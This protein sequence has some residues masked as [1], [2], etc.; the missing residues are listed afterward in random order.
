VANLGLS[1]LAC[2]PPTLSIRPFFSLFSAHTLSPLLAPIQGAS[3]GPRRVISPARVPP[4]A[5]PPFSNAPATSRVSPGRPEAG[6]PC[7]RKTASPSIHLL[8]LATQFSFR[9]RDV[10][11]SL[12]GRALVRKAR[13]GPP[14]PHP[15]RP[16][17][18]PLRKQVA[19]ALLRALLRWS[20]GRE[21]SSPT[22]LSPLSYHIPH[23]FFSIF[24]CVVCMSFSQLPPRTFFENHV[25]ATR[26]GWETVLAGPCSLL[27]PTTNT[28]ARPAYVGRRTTVR[29]G[30]DRWVPVMPALFIVSRFVSGA[31]RP[32]RPRLLLG[33][34]ER[35]FARRP[36][37]VTGAGCICPPRADGLSITALSRSSANVFH[38]R[39]SRRISPSSAIT[40]PAQRNPS[41]PVSVRS[42]MY[43]P[44]AHVVGQE[45]AGPLAPSIPEPFSIQ[46]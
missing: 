20:P 14:C 34:G 2:A 15:P 5:P 30:S 22:Y 25:G 33:S 42:P 9:A 17:A 6:K 12:A 39:G 44:A 40:S 36:N 8:R 26:V 46:P 3:G 32:A 27:V 21:T 23:V 45:P 35:E 4:R 11:T 38:D 29:G 10:T 37:G 41:R 28:T 24:S 13:R 19:V 16:Q 31:A 43:L 1:S 7:C 18:P